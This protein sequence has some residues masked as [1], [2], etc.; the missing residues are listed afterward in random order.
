[1]LRYEEHAPPAALASLMRCIWTLHG[2]G[3]PAHVD[4]ILPDGSFELVFHRGDVFTQNGKPQPRTMLVGELKS[5]VLVAQSA[6]IDVIGMRVRPGGFHALT[7]LD[8]AELA[9]SIH[10]ARDVF[11]EDELEPIIARLSNRWSETDARVDAAVAAIRR[12]HGR[13]RIGRLAS[14]LNVSERTL[15]RLFRHHVGLSPKELARVA[16]FQAEVSG[17]DGAYFD[18]SHRNREFRELAGATPAV[19]FAGRTDLADAFLPA[20]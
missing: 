8:A 15:E 14:A 13:L 2:D 19:V 3:S 10:D 7:G 12:R 16:R 4:R 18:D 6:R 1:M 9:G 5:A 11:G 20:G 17:K